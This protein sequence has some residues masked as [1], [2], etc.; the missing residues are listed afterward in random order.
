VA[1]FRGTV[2]GGKGEASR[3]GHK[4]TGLRAKV[5][6]WKLEAVIDADWDDEIGSNVFVLTLRRYDTGETIYSKVF[7]EEKLCRLMRDRIPIPM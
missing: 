7:M 3:I 6:S 4:T 5:N 1:Q 2:K